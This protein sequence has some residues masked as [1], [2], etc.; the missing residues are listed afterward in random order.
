MT[1]RQRTDRINDPGRTVADVYG[2]VAAGAERFL[3]DKLSGQP[4]IEASAHV[5]VR[6]ASPE[7]AKDQLLDGV[8]RRGDH[9][10]AA[11]L[12]RRLHGLARLPAALRRSLDHRARLETALRQMRAQLVNARELFGERLR[13]REIEVGH[14]VEDE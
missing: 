2:L 14:R 8:I 6:E 5:V 3:A 12:G 7:S 1:K 9:V 13:S 10:D 11:G 4:G